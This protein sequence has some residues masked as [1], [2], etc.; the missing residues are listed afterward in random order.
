MQNEQ[1]KSRRNRGV[2]APIVLILVGVLFLLDKS[3]I[4]DRH[5]VLQWWPL[6]PIAVGGWLLTKRINRQ[7]G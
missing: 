7:N 2:F 4:I 3:G 5:V 1:G 6:V